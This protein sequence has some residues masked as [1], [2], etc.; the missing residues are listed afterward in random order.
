MIKIETYRIY[1]AV[2]KLANAADELF[3]DQLTEE[4]ISEFEDAARR[5]GAYS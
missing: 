4:V 5:L 3:E 1:I 2:I